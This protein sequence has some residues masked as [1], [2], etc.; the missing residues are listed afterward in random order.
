[1]PLKEAFQDPGHGQELSQQTE[2]NKHVFSKVTKFMVHFYTAHLTNITLFENR[3][4][5]FKRH[6]FGGT[7]V[8]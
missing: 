4:L 1:M 5:F 7:W 3:I 8:V 6:P 2:D